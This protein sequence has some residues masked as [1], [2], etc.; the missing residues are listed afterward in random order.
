MEAERAV[1]PGG[2]HPVEAENVVVDVQLQSAPE[3]L[4]GGHGAALPVSDAG[5][6][7]AAAVPT[8]HHADEHAEHGA[9][10]DV[11]ERQ[12][13]AE[14]VRHGKHP[15][16]DRDERQHRL[17]EVCCLLGHPPAAAARADGP[18]LTGERDQAL[19][20]AVVAPHA[21]EAPPEIAAAQDVA[22]LA[23][24]EARHAGAVGGG[25]RLVEEAR[26]V[27]PHD[28]VEHRPCGRPWLVDSRQHCQST[29]KDVPAGGWPGRDGLAQW[30]S[31]PLARRCNGQRNR[32]LRSP[33]PW[34]G[35]S[36]CPPIHARQVQPATGMHAI[37]RHC[38]REA[39][40]PPH[41]ASGRSRPRHARIEHLVAGRAP[42]LF[43]E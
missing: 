39:D 16:A 24:D 6:P 28:L 29:A 13:V 34:G 32:S 17:D 43:C 27:R 4:H 38:P 33:R 18:G 36:P 15:L 41:S 21:T 22:E 42:V 10:E 9:A 35:G 20:R 12:A 3:A 26:E 30:N 7:G 40:R 8:E 11:V 1:A 37:R 14:P 25:G 5:V 2:E 19:E 23:L 31:G